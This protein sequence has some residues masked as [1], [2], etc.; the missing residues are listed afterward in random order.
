MAT[1]W[2]T[3]TAES[4]LSGDAA[5]VLGRDLYDRDQCLKQAGSTLYFVAGSSSAAGWTTLK[6]HGIRY[7]NFLRSGELVRVTLWLR[8]ATG[9][10]NIAHFRIQDS[11]AVVNGSDET[12]TSTT[13]V[14]KTSTLT[15]PDNTW[16]GAYKTLNIQFWTNAGTLYFKADELC[17]NLR[18]GD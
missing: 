14:L 2:P 6:T 15:V 3:R 13:F 17:A 16:A 11:G 9:G 5:K 12:T 4:V 18:F 8:H 1:T 7:P 10:A